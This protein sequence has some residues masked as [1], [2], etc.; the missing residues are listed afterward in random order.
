M[1]SQIVEEQIKEFDKYFTWKDGDDCASWY[2]GSPDY[3]EIISFL[4]SF[5]S[6]LIEKVRLEERKE[7]IQSTLDALDGMGMDEKVV[8]DE[9]NPEYH[10]VKGF[11]NAI[12]MARENIN[13]LL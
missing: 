4:R 1:T 10:Y 9:R 6:T 7:S 3:F 12:K 11:N 8:R 5:A 13:S 2:G